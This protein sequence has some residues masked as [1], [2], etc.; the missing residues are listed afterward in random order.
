IN[1]QLV[2]VFEKFNQ[3]QSDG[4]GK[5]AI[6]HLNSSYPKQEHLQVIDL[7]YI[8]WNKS[9]YYLN[10]E[11]DLQNADLYADSAEY[12]LP[13]LNKKNADEYVKTLF[14]RGDLFLAEKRYNEAF[15]Q[16]YEGK[17]YAIK[18]IGQ[19]RLSNFTYKLGNVKLK[20]NKLGEAITYY[21][22]ALQENQDCDAETFE[23]RFIYVQSKM[24][25]IAM[26][27]EMMYKPDSAII[28]YQKAINFINQEKPA[29]L[30]D[31]VFKE[32]AYGVVLGNL[33]GAYKMT[34]NYK[35]AER[36]LLK[37]IAINDRPNYEYQD[38]MTVKIKLADLYLKTNRAELCYRI[39]NKL[40]KDLNNTDGND[41]QQNAVK[42]SCYKLLKDYYIQ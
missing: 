31:S 3:L 41:E 39:V 37:S 7:W 16:Y 32:R 34:K 2:K 13:Q 18:N 17:A 38:A 40:L 5:L 42:L 29:N 27:Y 35:E 33:G 28:Y 23:Y 10:Y 26:V 8:Y 21:K 9:M 4:K 24:N 12:I 36:L 30:K 6:E 15:E 1:P 22:Q 14:L 19:C 20:Q 11:H 25:T